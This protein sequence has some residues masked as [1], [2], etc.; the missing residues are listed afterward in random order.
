MI[1]TICLA[2]GGVKGVCYISA[3]EYLEKVKFLDLINIKNYVGISWI[4]IKFFL[5][6]DIHA[7]N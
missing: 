3:I 6:W 4:N 1:D 5:Y 7:M 2:G